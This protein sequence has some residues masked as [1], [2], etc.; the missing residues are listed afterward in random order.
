MPSRYDLPHIDIARF[1]TTQG[2][3]RQNLHKI[4]QMPLVVVIFGEGNRESIVSLA[5]SQNG[6]F[7][8]KAVGILVGP[9][10]LRMSWVCKVHG[11]NSKHSPPSRTIGRLAVLHNT[12]PL[13]VSGTGWLDAQ[14]F[15]NVFENLGNDSL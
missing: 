7:S 14:T 5:Y 12:A 8:H 1:A 15:D 9:P 6:L 10:L 13:G 11:H 4:K 3:L 2:R